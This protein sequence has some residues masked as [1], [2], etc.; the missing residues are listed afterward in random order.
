LTLKENISSS[1]EQNSKIYHNERK[2]EIKYVYLDANEQKEK[3]NLN[4]HIRLN[5]ELHDKQT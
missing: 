2:K 5:L 4:L 1:S 3:Q